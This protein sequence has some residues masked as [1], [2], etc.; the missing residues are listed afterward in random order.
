MVT[1]QF[2]T[3]KPTAF[4][5]ISN[6]FRTGY[7]S[8]EEGKKESCRD[9][10]QTWHLHA[11][12]MPVNPVGLNHSLAAVLRWSQV[13]LQT[14][15]TGLHSLTTSHRQTPPGFFLLRL[16]LNGIWRPGSTLHYP[17]L[18]LDQS[19]CTYTEKLRHVVFIL[20]IRVL[21]WCCATSICIKRNLT[22]QIFPLP[23]VTS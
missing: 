5:N 4:P 15:L 10:F 13:T 9:T 18:S 12:A 1:K 22:S 11:H 3:S 16:L 6:C 7:M 20:V 2:F 23:S 14:G 19:Q 17:K 8:G 21:T